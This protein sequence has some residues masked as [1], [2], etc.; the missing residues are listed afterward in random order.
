MAARTSTAQKEVQIS[1]PVSAATKEL[2]DQ[3][4]RATGV[5]KGFLVE[6][7][8]RHHLEALMELPSDMIIHPR[9]VLTKKSFEAVGKLLTSNDKPTPALRKLMSGRGN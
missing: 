2:L 3:H 1:A 5:K 9:L 6:T 4:V 8:L 7:A